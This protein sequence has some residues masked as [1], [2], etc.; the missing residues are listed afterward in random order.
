MA[1]RAIEDLKLALIK[2]AIVGTACTRGK[3][4]KITGDEP[5]TMTDCSAGESP[6]AVALETQATSG[7]PCQ[8]VMLSGACI[9]KVLVGTGNAT[10]GKYA[11]VVGDGFA[12][13]GTL[14]GGTTA[15][16][17]AG[18]FVQSGVAGDYVGMQ[19]APF[20]SVKA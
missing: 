6:D 17:V 16:E 13:A 8:V 7:K 9:I 1:T 2:T 12:D 10:R 19:P 15:Q 18:K 20:T 3:G 4:V 5:M 14:G 11:K